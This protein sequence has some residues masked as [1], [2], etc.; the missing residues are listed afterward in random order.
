[1]PLLVLLLAPL[2]AVWAPAAEAARVRITV[3]TPGGIEQKVL[4]GR[5]PGLAAD[6]PVVFVMHGTRRD[7][8][9]EFERWYTL[10]LEREFLLVVPEFSTGDF[11]GASGYS[12]GNVH[13]AQGRVRPRSSWAFETIETIFDDLRQRF[14]MT[15]EGYAIYG[16]AA[17]AQ[18]VHRFLLHVPEA[19]VIRAVAANAGWYTMPDFAVGWPY[20]LQDSAVGE[21]QSR[22]ALQSPL[23]ILLGAED[24]ATDDP[25]LRRTPA[26][27]A[28][29][30]HRVA[31]GQSFCDAG[32]AAA[33]ERGIPSGWQVAIVPDTGHDSDLMAN[34]AIPYLLP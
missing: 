20:G 29:G 19:R 30:P 31:R 23:T 33:A 8:G 1:L 27:L 11:P 22:H 6:R 9:A 21:E 4:L 14:G 2:L 26:A 15:A 17:G 5:P 34:A 13:D 24:T 16:H 12:L 28:Q 25:G 18:F 7:V 3:Q 10:A 32:R